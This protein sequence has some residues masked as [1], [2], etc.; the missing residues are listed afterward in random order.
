MHHGRIGMQRTTLATQ[1]W[2]DLTD[3]FNRIY[4]QYVMPFQMSEDQLR[5][6][7]SRN[8]I[9]LEHSPLWL[10]DEG[11]V[12]ALAALGI[13]DER[14]WIGGFGVAVPYRGRGVS[15][16]LIAAVREGVRGLGLA[17]VQLEVISTNAA[18]IRTYERGGFTTRRT[19]RVWKRATDAPRL[20]SDTRSVQPG[21]PAAIVAR[22][23][24]FNSAPSWQREPQ[25]L[26]QTAG[27]QALAIGDGDALHAYVLYSVAPASLHIADLGAHNPADVSVLTTALID[28]YPERSLSLLNE[29]AD[30]PLCDALEHA[31]W[32]E[33]LQQ[34]ELHYSVKPF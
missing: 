25:S 3:A 18:A 32:H 1:S 31:G 8:D 30:S 23:H 34:Y 29:P 28:R 24:S 22:L 5:R 15:H 9:A 14:G 12:I 19:L 2:P 26:T 33:Q 11:N 17:T 10:D 27:L 16:R 6:H 13:R 21:D 4:Q 20:Q 7:F